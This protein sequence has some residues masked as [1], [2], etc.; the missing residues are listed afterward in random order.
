[1]WYKGVARGVLGC[2]WGAPLCMPFLSK[3]PTIFRGENTM[4]IMF[5]T[6]DPPLKHPGYAPVVCCCTKGLRA[7]EALLR[8]MRSLSL[9]IDSRWPKSCG[10]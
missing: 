8:N 2:Q 3:Q 6:V 10:L 5:D 4:T 9:S 1:M 7:W